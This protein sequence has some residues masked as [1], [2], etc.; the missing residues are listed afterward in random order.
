MHVVYR[1]ARARG[2]WSFLNPRHKLAIHALALDLAEH[3]DSRLVMFVNAGNH[4]HLAL[5]FPSREKMQAFLRVFGQR[6]MFLVTGARKGAPKGK[7][8][9]RIAFSRVVNWGREYNVL[10]NYFSKNALESFG[11]FSKPQLQA[12]WKN[13]KAVPL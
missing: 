4:L 3:Y 12:F 13:A 6:L 8:F 7:F 2:V 11:V 10:K 1:S 5:R 9:E